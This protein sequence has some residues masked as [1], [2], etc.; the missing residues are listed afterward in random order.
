MK[1]LFALAL[2]L[3]PLVA[4]AQL[5]GVSL[6]GHTSSDPGP[7]SLYEIDPL[8]G[9]GSLI[10]DIGYPVNSI[11]IDP[12]TGQMYAATPN[13]GDDAFVGLLSINP[14]DGAGT[15]VAE[16][17]D[18]GACIVNIMF[19]SSG[20]MYG[21]DE[22]SDASIDTLVTIDKATAA[23]VEVGPSGFPGNTQ[24]SV[25]A[26]D[27]SDTLHFVDGPS[28]IYYIFDTATGAATPQK[29]LTFS[30]GSGGSVIDPSGS[31][32]A[33]RGAGSGRI[34]DAFIRIS[35]V[36]SEN[37]VDVDTDVEYLNALTLADFTQ[38]AARFKVTKVFSDGSTDEVDVMLTCNTGLPLQQDFT[39]AGGD[40][41]GVTFVVTDI[42]DGG[43][44]CE[45]TESGTPAGYTTV[46]NG[47]AGCEWEDVTGGL[48]VCAI[49]NE[50][51]PATYTVYKD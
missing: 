34:Q 46:L 16:F 17:D 43:A 5:Y 7:S 45:V 39:I 8:S 36:D 27:S 23:V 15:E 37:F 13:W 51:N 48:R 11:A 42:P 14:S 9:A 2:A 50:A 3:L 33:P 6:N 22:C 32:W 28:Q 40:P 24:S 21:R 31:W 29:T 18:A 47:G 30:P 4:Q 49:T 20:Q 19:D 38:G 41:D 12:T 25:M 1:K 44:D 10:G 26:F 35:D